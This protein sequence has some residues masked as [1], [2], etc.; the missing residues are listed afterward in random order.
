MITIIAQN[1]ISALAI[2]RATANDNEGNRHFYGSKYFITWITPK[3]IEITTPRGL[4]SYWFRD[5]SFPHLPKYLTLSITTR[6]GKDGE[7]MTPEANAQLDIIKSLLAKSESIIVA[8]DPT[9]EGE[10]SFRYLYSYLH[11]T[12]PYSRAII[13][14]LTIKGVNR[15][16]SYTMPAEKYDKWY[17]A[18]NPLP[19]TD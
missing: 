3:M 11:C 4:V 17:N 12:L 19:K 16:I 2:A 14:D 1:K 18:A 5:Q 8:T 9:Q 6:S 15:A 7:S 13:N 10:M